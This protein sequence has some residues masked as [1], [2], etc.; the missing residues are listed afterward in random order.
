MAGPPDTPDNFP[1]VDQLLVEQGHARSRT[2]ARR[3]IEQGCV[4]QQLGDSWQ[5]V[6]K[7]GIKLPPDSNFRVQPQEEDRY[8]SRGGL[9]LAGALAAI[10][11]S[12]CGETWLDIGQSTGGFSDCLLQQGAKQVVGVDVGR[13]QLAAGL[14]E[15]RQ[16]SC[17]ENINARELP[18]AANLGVAEL[19]DGIC[20]D[21]SFISQ[22]LLV[23]G[24]TELLK[25]GALVVSLVKPQFELQPAQI[26]KGGIVRDPGLYPQVEQ[27]ICQAYQ[28]HGFVV[29]DYL[30]SPI[31]GGD[32]NREFFIVARK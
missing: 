22:T 28:K 27:R 4:E 6:K 21:V 19:F 12:V 3:W 7:P 25:P 17:F 32:G 1:R 23:P 30:P 26:G 2:Q 24:L 11:H 10:K 13:D 5:R 8:V 20:I 31:D 15:H 16:V 18:S 14:R 29:L 9:K